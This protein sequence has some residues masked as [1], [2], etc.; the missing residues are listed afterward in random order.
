MKKQGLIYD[1]LHVYRCSCTAKGREIVDLFW[2][3]K[4]DVKFDCVGENNP[5][6]RAR[7]REQTNLKIAHLTA[8]D[9]FIHKFSF[10][11]TMYSTQCM[12]TVQYT[13]VYSP[14]LICHKSQIHSRKQVI[15]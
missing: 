8:I 11:F 5:V 13:Y 6:Y 10:H 2:Q 9:A 7:A 14:E 1:K 15:D 12:Y 3:R 4:Q